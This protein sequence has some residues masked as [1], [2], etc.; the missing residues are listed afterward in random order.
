MKNS[1]WGFNYYQYFGG[2]KPKK[3]ARMESSSRQ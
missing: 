2:F 1:G 3:E